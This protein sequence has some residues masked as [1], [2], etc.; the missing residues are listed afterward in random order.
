MGFYA[1]YDIFRS[2][3]FPPHSPRRLFSQAPTHDQIYRNT[4]TLGLHIAQ[5]RSKSFV[6]P[7][8][9]SQP[10]DPCVTEPF[11]TEYVHVPI[12]LLRPNLATTP[13]WA[14]LGS[15]P[16]G[17]YHMSAYC[18]LLFADRQVKL[19]ATCSLPRFLHRRCDSHAS[20]YVRCTDTTSFPQTMNI[21]ER[22]E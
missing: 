14:H 4:S 13:S 11:L 1:F 22:Y 21:E 12:Q 3:L 9:H 6:H 8:G 2:F 15:H 7:T 18:C 5:C 16:V 17:V 19:Q 20:M 10:V